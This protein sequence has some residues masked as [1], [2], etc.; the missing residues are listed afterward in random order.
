MTPNNLNHCRRTR[1]KNATFVT[2][3]IDNSFDV[4]VAFETPE[5]LR[6]WGMFIEGSSRKMIFAWGEGNCC[7]LWYVWS[8]ALIE[9]RVDNYLQSKSFLSCSPLRPSDSTSKTILGF[10]WLRSVY[11]EL[12]LQLN[13]KVDGTHFFSSQGQICFR[14]FLPQNAPFSVLTYLQSFV[15][16]SGT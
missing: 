8:I 16:P 12:P 10:Y 5:S 6:S 7:S 4:C 14:P 2:S 9:S 1:A 11:V 13:E 15:R 3:K